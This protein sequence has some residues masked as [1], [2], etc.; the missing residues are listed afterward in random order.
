MYFLKRFTA[1]PLLNRLGTTYTFS[2]LL[3]TSTKFLLSTFF[4]SSTTFSDSTHFVNIKSCSI[5]LNSI[6]LLFSF[7][8]KL[9]AFSNSCLLSETFFKDSSYHFSSLTPFTRS[10]PPLH[11]KAYFIFPILRFILL[12]CSI[13]L[14]D[15]GTIR[16]SLFNFL[17]KL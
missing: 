6:V 15:V 5:N 16:I 12:Y 9:I 2:P 1:T 7:V 14:V 3:K 11:T 8:S 13:V 4:K 17:S 10:I